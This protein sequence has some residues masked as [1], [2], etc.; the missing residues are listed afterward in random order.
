ML[1]LFSGQLNQ[2]GNILNTGYI[3]EWNFS[4]AI[5]VAKNTFLGGNLT[6]NSG[7]YESNNDYYEDDT[8]FIYQNETAAGEP[9]TTDFQDF[10]F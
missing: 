10:L 6:Y 7:K 1:P 4:A 9:Q 5:E 8:Q 2:S 3:G